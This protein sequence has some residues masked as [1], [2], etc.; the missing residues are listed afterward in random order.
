[1]RPIVI[2]AV[3]AAVESRLHLVDGLEPG[4]P[5]VDPKVL[6]KQGIAGARRCR[7]TRPVN[8]L[9]VC[10][11]SSSWGGTARRG[12]PGQPARHARRRARARPQRTQ[13]GAGLAG[14]ARQ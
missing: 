2:V 1:M 8:P 5:A 6:V 14:Q 3:Q 13:K 10:T 12:S 4:A 11:I 7:W 9:V